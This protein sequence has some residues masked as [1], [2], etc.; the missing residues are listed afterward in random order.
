M[1]LNRPE[2]WRGR[3]VWA[4]ERYINPN[5]SA[6]SDPHPLNAVVGDHY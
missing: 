3:K 5:T 2:F 4:G 6:P 1:E